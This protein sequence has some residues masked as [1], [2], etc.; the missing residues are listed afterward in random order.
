MAFFDSE[1]ASFDAESFFDEEDSA[2]SPAS[3]YMNAKIKLD[4]NE[5]NE[6]DTLAASTRHIQAIAEPEAA[7][8]F[9]SPDPSVAAHQTAHSKL[10]D[11]INLRST[12]QA[13][14]QSAE[15]QAPKLL[16]DLK[17]SMRFRVDYVH[18]VANGDPAKIVLAGF[19][20]A[21][22]RTPVGELP[23]PLNLA[24]TMGA[25]GMLKLRWKPVTGASSYIIEMADHSTAPLA[26]AQVK[27]STRAS[28]EM[29]GLV[30]G[31]VYAFR[32][33]AVGA[34]GEGPWSD[35]AVKMAP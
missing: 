7:A 15:E 5:K 28:A 17:N 8:V 14:L 23:A 21:S 16:E 10:A 30:S 12:L 29:G 3:K 24:V 34:A 1:D 11:N 35:E 32:V 6:T 18:L 25:A 2:G 31:K 20:L 9:T 27:V 4:I 26:W 33:R 22:E 13:Q 19:D